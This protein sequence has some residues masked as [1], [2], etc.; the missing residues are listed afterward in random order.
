MGV[1][2]LFGFVISYGFFKIGLSTFHFIKRGRLHLN[3]VPKIR[4]D[5]VAL[6]ELSSQIIALVPGIAHL[7]FQSLDLRVGHRQRSSELLRQLRL[8]PIR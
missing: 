7:L 2:L 4:D 5:A 1:L 6:R 3:L 8:L